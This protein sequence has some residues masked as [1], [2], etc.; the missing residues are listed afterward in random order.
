MTHNVLC[1]YEP[2]VNF[3]NRERERTKSG[4]NMGRESVPHRWCMVWDKNDLVFSQAANE[5]IDLH[6]TSICIS[7]LLIPFH[8]TL[9]HIHLYPPPPLGGPD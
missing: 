3:A 5:I 9:C 2:V 8:L 4:S 1:G 7:I 6:S